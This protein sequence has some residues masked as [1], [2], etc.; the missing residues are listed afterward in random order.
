[1]PK[2]S[3]YSVS[4]CGSALGLLL[5]EALVVELALEAPLFFTDPLIVEEADLVLAPDF[6][7]LDFEVDLPLAVELELLDFWLDF[8]VLLVVAEPDWAAFVELFLC[9]EV[10][11]VLLVELLSVLLV[12]DFFGLPFPFFAVELPELVLLVLV[13][14]FSLLLFELLALVS[15]L[16]VLLAVAKLILCIVHLQP[17]FWVLL[18]C[19]K[20]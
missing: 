7:G 15:V 14:E 20:E 10:V 5:L 8:V 16:L 1:M 4:I 17:M 11:L 9:F 19:I 6:L 2:L 12:S 18:S 13:L 3:P